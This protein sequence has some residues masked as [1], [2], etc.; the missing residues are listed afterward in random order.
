MIDIAIVV[1][2]LILLI[3]I[4]RGSSNNPIILSDTDGYGVPYVKPPPVPFGIG[5]SCMGSDAKFIIN[6]NDC[7]GMQNNVNT[8]GTCG[9]PTCDQDAEDQMVFTSNPI[10]ADATVGLPKASQADCLAIGGTVIGN[11]CRS[12]MIKKS[13]L[14]P[15]TKYF[16]PLALSQETSDVMKNKVTANPIG[17]F[18]TDSAVN[19]A[20]KYDPASKICSFNWYTFSTD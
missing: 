15:K 11:G 14:N 10:G 5:G 6:T 18:Y 20:G 1:I 2:V 4:M 9:I 3:W 16:G 13:S 19:C 7:K 17:T 12:Y 8:D